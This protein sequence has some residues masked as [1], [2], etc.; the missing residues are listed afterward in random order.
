MCR[1]PKEAHW[2]S[3]RLENF[4]QASEMRIEAVGVGDGCE[5]GGHGWES[6]SVPIPQP[7]NA[8]HLMAQRPVKKCGMG[9]LPMCQT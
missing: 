1:Q 3:V 8:F 6:G 5:R 2:H 9:I 4:L 7:L